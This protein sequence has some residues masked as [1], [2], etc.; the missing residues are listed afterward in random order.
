MKTKFLYIAALALAVV[1]SA[2]E[3]NTPYDTQSPDDAPLILRPYNESG[4][5]S[6]TYNLANPDTPLYDSV[7]VTPSKYTTVNWYIDGTLVFTGLKIEQTFL[8][9]SYDLLI[10][11]VTQAGKRTER[12]GT[13]TVHP[14]DTDPYSAAPAAGRHCVP[15]NPATLDGANLTKVDKVLLTKDIYGKEIVHTIVPDAGATDAQLTIT[16]PE[17]PDGLYYVRFM[18]AEGKMY[19]AEDINV[20]NV[21]VAL[22]GYASFVPGSEWTITGVKL[23]NVA[24]VKVDETL[25]TEL[26]ATATSITF[27]APTAEVGDHKLSIKNADGSSVYFITAEGLVDEVTTNVSAETTIWEGSCVI[28]WGDSKVELTSD[29]MKDVPVGSTIYIYFNIPEAEYHALRVT[30]DWWSHDL[31]PQVDGMEGQPNPYTFVYDDAGKAAVDQT[32]KALVT[33]FGIEI[34]KVTFK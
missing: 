2:C 11:A 14:Y 6:F 27:T 17:T 23:D 8:T 26:V 10:E 20:H 16:L 9:G 7:T 34:T 28:N 4:I 18:D 3:N 21:S 15:G 33:G 5:G 13:V 22:D 12:K 29:M 19:G 1:F 30:D 32:G 25:I 24:S 31:L